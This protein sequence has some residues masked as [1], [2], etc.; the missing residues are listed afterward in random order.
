MASFGPQQVFPKNLYVM[1]MVCKF[2]E[3]RKN[4]AMKN[5]RKM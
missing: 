3:E 4:F 1:V 5:V 2:K